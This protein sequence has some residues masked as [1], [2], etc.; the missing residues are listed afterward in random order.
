MALAYGEY[1]FDLFVRMTRSKPLLAKETFGQRLSSRISRAASDTI[2]SA[3]SKSS[4][5]HSLAR[6]S[7]SARDFMDRAC[8]FFP[9]CGKAGAHFVRKNRGEALAPT[10]SFSLAEFKS[11]TSLKRPRRLS[12]S[13]P[14][15]GREGESNASI[16]DSLPPASR[17]TRSSIGEPCVG[18]R[19]RPKAA[20]SASPMAMFPRSSRTS[21]ILSL[22]L[23]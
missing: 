17:T 4:S 7:A 3:P 22:D 5:R 1:A 2:T 12:L 19:Y 10:E 13:I 11:A 18:K 15:L 6:I 21:A 23:L 9:R 16:Q 14:L 20:R 8:V